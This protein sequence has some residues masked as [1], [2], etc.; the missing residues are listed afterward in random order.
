VLAPELAR[1]TSKASFDPV[2]WGPRSR[3]FAASWDG[4]GVDPGLVDE[5]A[6]RREWARPDPHAASCHL[7]QAAWL[8]SAER[9]ERV[10][11]PGE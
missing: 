4:S 2:F 10:D 7:L 1:R 8:A 6:L 11:R 5:T 9:E 3:A